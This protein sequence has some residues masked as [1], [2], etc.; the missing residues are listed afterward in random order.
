VTKLYDVIRG[1]I[2]FANEELDDFII[3][4]SDGRPTYNF[5]VVVDDAGMRITHV[6]RGDDHIS[7]TPRQIL[8]YK[9]FGYALPKFAHLPMILGSDRGRLSKRHGATSI[10]EYRDMGFLRDALVNYLAL[11]GWAYDGKTEI[12]SRESLIDK[13][14]LK[15]VSKN[16]A[17]FDLE[18]LNYINAEHFKKMDLMDKAKMIYT[19]LETKDIF[20]PDF[21]VPEWHP[22]TGT[23]SAA[24]ISKAELPRLALIVKSMGARLKR[25]DEIPNLLRYFYKDDYARD[26]AAYQEHLKD[27]EIASHLK[28]LA[29]TIEEVDPFERSEIETAVRTLAGD[30]GISAG[31]LIHPCRVALTGQAVSPDIFTVFQLLGKEKCT[32]RL[33]AASEYILQTFRSD[34]Q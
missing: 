10:Q 23:Q 3:S 8:L 2:E 28:A 15:R 26:K 19:I 29:R 18:K 34:T 27:S 4:K 32:A 30:L 16:P 33:T 11:L 25:M 6:I 12:F 14:S 17:A 9:A 13:F 31:D 20:P 5:A 22:T 1:T 21:T 7:N 24:A